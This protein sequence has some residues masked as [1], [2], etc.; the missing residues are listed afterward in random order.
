MTDSGRKYA[1][2]VVGLGRIGW[3]FN[4]DPKVPFI[5]SHAG[6]YAAHDRFELVAAADIDPDARQAFQQRYAEVPTFASLEAL[7]SEVVPDCLSIATHADSHLPLV[8][9]AVAAGVRGIWCEKPLAPS[10]DEAR[11][12]VCRCREA[13]VV[14]AVNHWRRWD[15]THRNIERWLKSGTIG[16]VRQVT[17]YWGAGIWNTGVHL[18][19]LLEQWFGPV[20][21]LQSSEPMPANAADPDLDI[22]GGFSSGARFACRSL[23]VKQEYLMF[24]G[25]VFGSEGRLEVMTNAEAVRIWRAAASPTSSEYRVLIETDEGIELEKR[26]YMMN[27]ATD[28]ARCLDEGDEPA[29]TGENG[30][31]AV[32]CVLAALKSARTRQ[33]V[34]LEAAV[35]SAL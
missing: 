16:Q 31:R 1:A 10:V 5:Q 27:A 14:L 28:M 12:V 19:D 22:M 26:D 18:F 4:E 34:Q 21:W 13:G 20:A 24:A 9:A 32:Q 15:G 29:C 30:L 8:E 3:R 25:D 6:A 2:A 7:L 33:V 11:Q 23:P 35:S 17:C